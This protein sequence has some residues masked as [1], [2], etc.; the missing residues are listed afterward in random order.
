M[1]CLRCDIQF[2]PDDILV[3]EE[4]E[5]PVCDMCNAEEYHC[6]MDY[7]G[8]ED[9]FEFLNAEIGKRN[10][11]DCFE[12]SYELVSMKYGTPVNASLICPTCKGRGKMSIYIN[13][14]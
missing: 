4:F 8:G 13:F 12:G 10:C 3:M 9:L 6:R 7:N 5:I 2:S 1:K 11:S 14:V